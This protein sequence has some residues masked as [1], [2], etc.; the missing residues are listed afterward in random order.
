M[1]CKTIEQLLERYWQCETS[2]EEETALRH[3]FLSEEVPAHLLRYRSLFAYQK[4]Q[5]GLGLDEAFDRRMLAHIEPAVVQ[6]RRLT[7]IGQLAPLFKAAAVV[8]GF[9]LLGN[10]AEQSF[11]AEEDSVLAVDTIGKQITTPSV[12]I[13]QEAAKSESALLTDSL[14][15]NIRQTIKK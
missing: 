1:D 11:L 12:A 3:F 7:L 14:P 5:Q 9:V 13:S 10:V 6:A 4:Q 15:Q 2:L 8:A